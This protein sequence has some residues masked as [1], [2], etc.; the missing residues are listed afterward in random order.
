MIC[1]Y[2][3]FIK[4]SNAL[5][6]VSSWIQPGMKER[7][8]KK[9]KKYISIC[10]EIFFEMTNWGET[11]LSKQLFHLNDLKRNSREKNDVVFIH[12]IFFFVCA[13][14]NFMLENKCHIW[15]FIASKNQNHF[16][17]FIPSHPVNLSISLTG[18]KEI[19]RDVP[20]NGEWKGH[21]A[22]N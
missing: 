16:H 22:H 3:W 2:S 4:A 6:G 11:H 8:D 7:K 5:C 19:K 17:L 15:S 9:T 13:L 1:K 12:H 21:L 14:Q 10:L 20:S 18:G